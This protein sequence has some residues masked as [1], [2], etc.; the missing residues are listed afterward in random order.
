MTHDFPRFIQLVSVGQGSDPCL[1]DPKM[2]PVILTLPH[3]RELTGVAN[4]I[5]WE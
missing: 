3:P 5:L 2:A 1:S 4:R